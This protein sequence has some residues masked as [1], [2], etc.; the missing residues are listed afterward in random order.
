MAAESRWNPL[1]GLEPETIVQY[2]EMFEAGDFSW[3]DRTMRAMERRDDIWRISAAKARKD[4][5]RRKWEVVPLEGF[6]D[7]ADAAAQVDLLQGFYRRARSIDWN[8]RSVSSGMRGVIAGMMRAYQDEWSVAEIVWRPEPSG[9]LSAD[10]IRAPLE[11]FKLQHGA[12]CV[13]PDGRT[14]T[15]LE[16]GG[17]L[18]THG[19]GVGVACAVAYTLK[20]LALGDWA[21]YCGRCG[22]P[23]IHGKTAAQKGTT[24]WTD[25][26]AALR[27]FGKEWAAATGLDDVIEKIDL[28]VSGTL[29]YPGLVERMD[30][31]I[32]SLQRG[33]DLSTLSAGSGA[34]DGASL[35]GDE[36]D[37]ISE[38]NCA[39]VTEALRSQVDPY[40][41]AWH[42]GDGVEVKAG[43]RLIPPQR[44][45]VERDIKI[46]TH[47]LAAGARL[48]KSDALSRYE[49]REVD[50]DDAEDEPLVAPVAPGPVAAA[51]PG[52]VAA[53]APAAAFP[54]EASTARKDPIQ[55]V[56][57]RAAAK[58]MDG[59]T[60]LKEAL[61]AA[62]AEVRALP[63]LAAALDVAEFQAAL[64]S[65]M[66][67]AAAGGAKRKVA[68]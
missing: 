30:R 65:A 7:D 40:V 37:L 22:H 68:S 2:I 54:N 25:F 5:S 29:P 61:D 35:Q 63:G 43:F 67:E 64:E 19:D 4:V 11:L 8:C 23:G 28:S 1:R 26:T 45:T 12:M 59:S 9:R 13:V 33:A 56:L 16:D 20:R 36:A 18:L 41:L 6:E 42:R 49:R 10:F 34:G 32:A 60:P 39:T 52:S 27:A 38:D 50:P 24:Q 51:A 15:P 47:L 57:A 31:A 53:A 44:D 55:A 62:L 66:F 3:L 14:A 17:W 48:S 58:I 46:D 21:V